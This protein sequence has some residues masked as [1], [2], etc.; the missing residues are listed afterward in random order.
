VGFATYR[1]DA[2]GHGAKRRDEQY[3]NDLREWLPLIRHLLDD[4]AS[5]SPWRL[6]LVAGLW[7]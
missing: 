6:A 2:L 7:Y 3:E 5:L 4:V 1:N